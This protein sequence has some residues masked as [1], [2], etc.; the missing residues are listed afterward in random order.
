MASLLRALLDK[1][2]W[3]LCCPEEAPSCD[4]GSQEAQPSCCLLVAVKL[5]GKVKNT[6]EFKSSDSAKLQLKS[7]FFKPAILEEI[8]SHTL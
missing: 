5:N 4:E 3:P 1:L 2:D 6:V 7:K 8:D